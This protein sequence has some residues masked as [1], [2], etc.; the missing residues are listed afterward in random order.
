MCRF[1]TLRRA[2][3]WVLVLLIALTYASPVFA[4]ESGEPD[5]LAEAIIPSVHFSDFE[6]LSGETRTGTV[7]LSVRSI[8]EV[9]FENVDV[10]VSFGPGLDVKLPA[11]PEGYTAAFI[12]NAD[13]S[14]SSLASGHTVLYNIPVLS[15]GSTGEYNLAV[16]VSF[17]NGVTPNA[18][19]ADVVVTSITSDNFAA[20]EA[21]AW[22]LLAGEVP[23]YC[24]LK[25]LAQ[26]DWKYTGMT[27]N[28]GS[29]VT[30]YKLAET[31]AGGTLTLGSSG[32][33]FKITAGDNRIN[34][35]KVME[36]GTINAS[37]VQLVAYLTLPAGVTNLNF[38]PG[39]AGL[40]GGTW[41]ETDCTVT[42]L[43]DASSLSTVSKSL[44]I[45]GFDW[46][47]TF[48][49]T[50]EA[51]VTIKCETKDGYAASIDAASTDASLAPQMNRSFSVTKP[52]KVIPPPANPADVAK[53][54]DKKLSTKNSGRDFI[55][56]N[57]ALVPGITD[58][59]K[60]WFD[61]V[62]PDFDGVTIPDLNGFEVVDYGYKTS[63]MYPVA[64][65]DG[66]ITDAAATLYTPSEYRLYTTKTAYTSYTTLA[67]ANTALATLGSSCVGVAFVYSAGTGNVYPALTV[68]TPPSVRFT[69][70]PLF[71]LA[72]GVNTATFQNEAWLELFYGASG[73]A[74]SDTE[75]A[76]VTYFDYPIGWM[77]GSK[78]SDKT[79]L[80][81]GDSVKHSIT[82]ANKSGSSAVTNILV[83]DILTAIPD[84]MPGFDA[85]SFRVTFGVY[86]LK[87]D[88]T[89]NTSK[90]V[91]SPA[92]KPAAK[93]ADTGSTY[94]VLTYTGATA[95]E[96]ALFGWKSSTDPKLEFGLYFDGSLPAGQ[97]M[98]IE[99]TLTVPATMSGSV[100][101]VDNK[102]SASMY[103]ITNPGP[104]TGPG[105]SGDWTPIT[106]TT[107]GETSTPITS[108]LLAS[109]TKDRKGDQI[110]KNGDTVEYEICAGLPDSARDGDHPVIVDILSDGLSFLS[111]SAPQTITVHEFASRGNAKTA[112]VKT[113]AIDVDYSVVF[114]NADA[115]REAMVIIFNDKL[116]KNHLY[117]FT[118]T[119]VLDAAN[120]GSSAGTDVQNYDYFF[121]DYTL[122][123]A[124]MI[125]NNPTSS[126]SWASVAQPVSSPNDNEKLAQP[127]L[128]KAFDSLITAGT[129]I[130]A[131]PIGAESSGYIPR[132]RNNAIV[133][134]LPDVAA[135]VGIKKIISKVF[136]PAGVSRYNNATTHFPGTL[137]TGDKVTYTGEFKNYG[138]AEQAVEI[139]SFIDILPF[140]QT[141]TAGS[142]KI[143]T[144]SSVAV[145]ESY[146]A[147]SRTLTV[148]FAPITLA[149]Q[150]TVNFTYNAEV[151]APW[152]EL[153]AFTTDKNRIA[154]FIDYADDIVVN[155]GTPLYIP[156]SSHVYAGELD[157][158]VG[159]LAV[160]AECA[161]KYA[162]IKYPVDI[163]KTFG[164]GNS[165][166]NNTTGLFMQTGDRTLLNW[167][168]TISSSFDYPLDGY[169]IIDELPY[170]L[171]YDAGTNPLTVKYKNSSNDAKTAS[172]D[173]AVERYNDTD[174]I[175]IRGLN[176][177]SK[178]TGPIVISL[179]SFITKG[180]LGGGT[181]N[182]YLIPGQP[183][184]TNAS[185]KYVP[186][187]DTPKNGSGAAIAP[188]DGVVDR[189]SYNVIS[190]YGAS[191]YKR[192]TNDAGATTTNGYV[193]TGRN[194]TLT[195]D[196]VLENVNANNPYSKISFID[197]L[198]AIGDTGVL[199]STKRLSD[200]VP[201][202]AGDFKVFEITS[203]NVT[204]T[205]ITG[206]ATVYLG[207]QPLGTDL[208][209][210]F[211]TKAA[212]E[213]AVWTELSA[214][215]A[216][217]NLEQYTTIKV[218][219]DDAYT[220]AK[221]KG[222]RLHW[223]MKVP[224]DAVR[225]EITWNSAAFGLTSNG[226]TFHAEP[227][228]VGAIL[229]GNSTTY[230]NLTLKKTV[231]RA[232]STA[233][234]FYFRVQGQD[235]G[236]D[237]IH[238]ITVPAN[239]T[240]PDTD[241]VIGGML[242]DNYTV[243]EVADSSGTPVDADFPYKATY[244]V[245]G[246]AVNTIDL[247]KDG[248]IEITN[249]RRLF[250][251]T[252]TKTMLGSSSPRTFYFKLYKDGVWLDT[253]GAGGLFT[254]T[255]AANGTYDIA[256]LSVE[257]GVYR[258]EEV[259]ATGSIVTSDIGFIVSHDP[260][261]TL[262]VDHTSG[263]LGVKNSYY[264]PDEASLSLAVRKTVKG[265][266]DNAKRVFYF[267]LYKGSAPYGDIFS[268]IVYG[269][270]TNSRVISDLPEGNYSVVE[271]LATG[272]P[273]TRENTGFSIS[274]SGGVLLDSTNTQAT[275]SVTNSAEPPANSLTVTKT[276]LGA[277]DDEVNTFYFQL[278]RN[279]EKF[280][281]IF[282]ITVTGNGSEKVTF[283]N[284][285]SGRYSVVEV[286]A[287][288]TTATY[289]NIGFE[290]TYSGEVDLG[291]TGNGFI[292]VENQRPDE[293][294]EPDPP[295]GPP[296]P[297]LP[298]EGPPDE[299]FTES[300]VPL[301]GGFCISMFGVFGAGLLGAGFMLGKKPK[302]TKGV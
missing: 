66:V 225:N 231:T 165:Y 59:N 260:E 135:N 269:D 93:F 129:W 278:Y 141:Y 153:Q 74:K 261:I 255:A 6:F 196:F 206:K 44:T 71:K 201:V 24:T 277:E 36:N 297:D 238:S 287:D 205:D 32:Y 131:N 245:G 14:P 22:D 100:W 228:K 33:T 232:E 295:L 247:Y 140:G 178:T 200:W 126:G 101:K 62:I 272:T 45:Y 155:Q 144:P 81:P 189:K 298:D 184:D 211:G 124:K 26:I 113:L 122:V 109:I 293:A 103:T 134:I 220:L 128:Q 54:F 114:V 249:E 148:T 108:N 19:P 29:S 283:E 86:E 233:R 111:D 2:L 65:A 266:G 87:S 172:F 202:M 82:V 69:A 151:T 271:V 208:G 280:R 265:T 18:F 156:D 5:S 136:N 218:E 4:N 43:V 25:A 294:W 256:K 230:L 227:V 275:I 28:N 270:T 13:G 195:F 237:Q 299:P 51:S 60:I 110:R 199:R 279:G 37:Q 76:S 194:E 48:A 16:D 209:V 175:V 1:K 273:A 77:T 219:M 104:G 234:T 89:I 79:S 55:T 68:T 289:E 213:P 102:A 300:D 217:G 182:A 179:T 57:T 11:S 215:V 268:I 116:A 222:L 88:G 177:L 282:S 40:N 244:S 258:L 23:Y 42:W 190:S 10:R 166:F 150:K 56:N 146:D 9:T 162:Y 142:F 181:N 17:P 70:N 49:D 64:L 223:T 229:V 198:P 46:A 149:G 123:G 112:V 241:L 214:A 61:L 164:S 174:Y 286:L 262:D 73:T 252:L 161:V 246:A 145:T 290:I 301:T 78:K 180:S 137:S 235:T 39:D 160:E 169:T 193:T 259:T 251:L 250:E 226:A 7:I 188:G 216:G 97:G 253:L 115:K 63:E 248:T 133:K 130:A 154:T 120:P 186:Q 12:N 240:V 284:L 158:N 254:V 96:R 85:A 197:L 183:F 157:V 302:K 106:F 285:P 31:F 210:F 191:S 107:V 292:M 167:E 147:T 117:K 3:S 94:K 257:A 281:D 20:E 263:T 143:T 47:G 8:D 15:T 99:Y 92:I 27:I 170:N 75:Y 53:Q 168:I 72:A 132:V 139:D 187:S 90:P 127:S 159:K 239:K 91:A 118:T 192:I 212:S 52:A 67:A 221:G 236:Y 138:A 242:E 21:T 173:V 119:A 125:A 243:T 58:A 224:G 291:E 288:G 80:F 171:I 203:S 264:V 38:G 121:P 84:G 163:T 35:S 176:T 105:G 30:P 152:S 34:S 204:G 185:S 83:K 276:V 267:Q 98:L 274:V 296:P 207:T 95:E 41:S 50:T